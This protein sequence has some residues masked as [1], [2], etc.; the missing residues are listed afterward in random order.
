MLDQG[1]RH[2]LVE[3]RPLSRCVV[4]AEQIV[5]GEA[6]DDP[7]EDGSPAD[8]C[9][10][11]VSVD[12]PPKVTLVR[13]DCKWGD[14]EEYRELRSSERRETEAC[15][16]EGVGT[17]RRFLDRALEQVDG[18]EECRVGRRLRED[19]RGEDEPR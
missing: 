12:T 9:Q 11:A 18:P 8:R 5:P 17:A 16:R 10:Q 15:D 2:M 3:E 4:R 1:P 19:E 14:H 7:R 13:D 6:H